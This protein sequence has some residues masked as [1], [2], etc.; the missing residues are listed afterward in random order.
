MR[1]N[2][3]LIEPN[4][5]NK[6]P[7]IGL[8]KIA[9]YHRML[10][11]NVRYFKGD[12]KDLI[13]DDLYQDCLFELTELDNSIDWNTKQLIIKKYIKNKKIQ[14]IEELNLSE[15][16]FELLIIDKLEYYANI[17]KKK[18]YT[19][20][21]R[22]DRI[23]VTT[24]F[25]FYWKITIATIEF[26]KKLVKNRNELHVGGVL[27]SLLHKEVEVATGIVPTQGLLDK[28]GVLD[29]DNLIAKDII[30][31]NLPLDYSI[32]DEIDYE[33]P[34]RSAYF[35]FM[36]KGCTRKCS[37]CSVPILEPTYKPKI[38]TFDKFQEIKA[39]FGDQ[40]N[41]LLMD[42]NV[43]ASPNFAEI[44]D[45]IKAMGFYKGATFVEPN[46]LAI[47]IENLKSGYND[48]GFKRRIFRLIHAFIPKLK[49][50]KAQVFY[51][52][53]ADYQLLKYETTTKEN[54]LNVYP[55]IAGIYEKYR[56]KQPKLRYV[57]FNQ[58]TDARYVTEEFMQKMSEIPIRPLRIAFDYIGLKKQYVA[59]VRLAAKYGIKELSNYILYNFQDKPEDLYARLKINADLCKELNVAIFSF[60]MKYIPLFG[61]EA[62]HRMFTGKHW[63][64]KF[65]RAIQSILNVTKGIVAPSHIT[66]ETSFFEEAFGKNLNEFLEILYMPETYIVYRHLFRY[67]LNYT[68]IWRSEYYGL[69]DDDKATA[70]I[71][72]E[73]NVYTEEAINKYFPSETVKNFLRHYT[74]PRGS[75][76]TQDKDYIN[77]K[78]KYDKLIKE[79]QFIN[80]TLTYDFENE[81][82]RSTHKAVFQ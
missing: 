12:L 9:T 2:I 55:L 23:Y 28:P 80:L 35:T 22:Y 66:E 3:L 16:K 4:Y 7:P 69:S 45:E 5:S 65:I 13:I 71:I 53:L 19:Q 40:Q 26:C 62:K 70:H 39:R 81:K 10:G 15:S 64:K 33:Y 76:D 54:I 47:A 18:A 67:K 75:I 20:F 38:E 14:F 52:Y 6:Y 41:L 48:N 32:L 36:T 34:T 30:I 58:G 29:P 56:N 50:D 72:I 77:L 1:R 43:L 46:Q 11:D 68:E 31:D 74:I 17:F 79:D 21:P 44:I 63:N 8:M 27:A 51:N 49:G 25:T 60:P 59:A 24:L 61:E 57:D 73:N 42:N 37:F 78:S 82:A